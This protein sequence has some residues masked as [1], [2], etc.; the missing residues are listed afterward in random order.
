MT[1]FS[2]SVIPQMTSS[3]IR[4]TGDRTTM[5]LTSVQDLGSNSLFGHS[6]SVETPSMTPA[7]TADDVASQHENLSA[8]LADFDAKLS[9]QKFDPKTGQSVGFRIEGRERELI[10][11]QKAN[12]TNQLTWLHARAQ[13]QLSRPSRKDVANQETAERY[14]R[15]L[16]IQA[17]SATRG[18]DGREIGCVAAAR[19]I[20]AEI[21]KVKTEALVRGQ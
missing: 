18:A 19:M 16:R 10:E 7:M 2:T 3:N 1:E 14:G 13:E 21:A 4:V 6:G 11:L 20:D 8:K 5:N 12:M 15:E 9:A 17:L